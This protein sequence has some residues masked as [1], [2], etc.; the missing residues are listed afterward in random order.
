MAATAPAGL[1]AASTLSPVDQT[2]ATIAENAA[3]ES[4]IAVPE[5]TPAKT[6]TAT[7]EATTAEKPAEATPTT[8]SSPFPAD[9][10]KLFEKLPELTKKAE[11]SEIWGIE[12]KPDHIPTAIILQKFLRANENDLEKAESQLKEALEW[13]KKIQALKLVDET[14]EGEKFSGLGYVTTYEKDGAKE[15]VTWN[16]YGAV[17]SMETTF[18]NIE[19]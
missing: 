11:Y 5:A 15:V 16:I 10:Q 17:K 14:F 19:E 8:D 9:V 3:S 2:P 4:V 1:V 12:L 18:G 6:E 13:R 7:T